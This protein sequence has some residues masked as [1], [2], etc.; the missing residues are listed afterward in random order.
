MLWAAAFLFVSYTSSGVASPTRAANDSVPRL[1]IRTE[2]SGGV[3]ATAILHLPVPPRIV[4]AVLTDYE[5]WPELFGHRFRIARLE[6]TEGRVVTDLQ[7]KRSP[8][9]G[10]LR[11]LC[12]TKRLPDGEL[13]TSLIEG[14]FKRY[15][16]RWKIGS[17]GAGDR[18]R[19]RAEMELRLELASWAPTWLVTWSLRR[20]LEEHFRIL[21]EWVVK[22]FRAETGTP[23]APP[24][25]GP[26]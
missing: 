21:H 5:H 2:P 6:R 12:E 3:L 4:L 24:A 25:R 26:A 17:D 22:R 13:V 23:P 11:L 10:E 1:E 8:F 19:T 16:R 15:V 20:E 14:D 9:P 18:N 7:I